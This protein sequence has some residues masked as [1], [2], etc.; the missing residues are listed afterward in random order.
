VYGLCFSRK[1]NV[2][3]LQIA[4]SF[5]DTFEVAIG[6]VVGVEVKITSVTLFARKE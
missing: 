5:T 1:E 3:I 4:W 2:K 6:S